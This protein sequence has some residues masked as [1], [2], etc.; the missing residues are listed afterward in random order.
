M[1]VY[2]VTPIL[3]VSDLQQSFAWFEKLGWR[4]RWEYGDPPDFGAVGNTQCEIFLCQNGQGCRRTKQSDPPHDR[5]AGGIWLTWLLASPAQVDAAHAAALA[6][7]VKVLQPPADR[8]WGLRECLLEHPDGHLFR[9]GAGLDAEQHVILT[10]PGLEIERIDVSVRLEAHLA[11]VLRELAVHKGMTVGE[12]LE[13]TLLHTFE[14]TAGGG[15]ASPHTESTLDYIQELRARHG[16]DYDCHASY[17]FVERPVP[18]GSR[19]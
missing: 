16:M 11:A 7:G 9:V 6:Q 13:E 12:C 8:P 19:R 14:R 1:D 15:V 5:D 3:N 2:S 17:R 10:E 4:K 18:G